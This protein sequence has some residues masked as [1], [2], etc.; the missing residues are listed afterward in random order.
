M[1]I[2]DYSGKYNEITR[3]LMEVLRKQ[4]R[5][6]TSSFLQRRSLCYW[7]LQ[8]MRYREKQ[9]MKSLM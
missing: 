9:E 5:E 2:K 1:E 4:K 3:Y 7:A 6:K 8:R